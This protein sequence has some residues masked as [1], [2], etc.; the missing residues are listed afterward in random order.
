[1]SLPRAATTVRWMVAFA[2]GAGGLYLLARVLSQGGDWLTVFAKSLYDLAALMTGVI[3][4]SPELVWWAV[5]PIHRMLDHLLLPS[6]TET[7][8]VDF[9]LARFYARGLRY[10]EACEEYTKIIAYHPEATDAYLEGIRAAALGGDPTVARK[11]YRGARRYLRSRDERRLL[12]AVYKSCH[13]VEHF[14]E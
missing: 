6:E 12:D 4:V 8:P 13:Q 2:V 3:L 10:E 11:F 1:M 9:R 14:V 5:T 7:P